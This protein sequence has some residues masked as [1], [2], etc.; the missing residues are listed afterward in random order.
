MTSQPLRAQVAEVA[1][2]LHARGW[3]ANHDGNISLKLN[4]QRLLITP[5]AVSKGDVDESMLLIVDYSGKVLEGRRKPFSELELLVLDYAEGM[6][7][8]P[9]AVSDELVE[10]LRAHLDDEQ[11][12]ELTAVIALENYRARFNWALGIAGQGFAEGGAC[13]VPEVAGEAGGAN[14]VRA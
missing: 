1:R 13:A 10:R 7:S 3:V 11:L 8:T 2:H 14:E 6:T 9:V 5:T 12:V 4:G